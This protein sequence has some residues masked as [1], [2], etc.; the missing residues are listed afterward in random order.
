MIGMA[1]LN[2]IQA[3]IEDVVVEGV[4]GD[5]VETGVGRGGCNFHACRI[6]SLE[7]YGPVS[8]V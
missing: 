1:R 6:E 7:H 3:W 2:N 4:S 8:L 5:L